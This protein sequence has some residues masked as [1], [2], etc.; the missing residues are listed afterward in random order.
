MS[1]KSL[2]EKLLEPEIAVSIAYIF[3][4][5]TAFV[6]YLIPVTEKYLLRSFTTPPTAAAYVLSLLG[7]SVYVVSAR[8]GKK[9]EIKNGLLILFLVALTT[10]AVVNLTLKVHS[11][12]AI[13]SGA[14][15]AL[16]LFYLGRERDFK[17]LTKLVFIFAVLSALSIL[18]R[19]IPILSASARE[20][21]AISTS[22][23]LFH[24]FGVFTGALL[25]GFFDK[26]TAAISV[27]MLAIIGVLSGF[28][29]DA[30]AIILSASI[31]G[32]LLKK[33]SIKTGV[34]SLVAIAFILTG[35]STFIALVA[36]DV[37]NIPPYLYPFYRFGF[38]F[39]VFSKVVELALPF[40]WLHGEAILDTTQMIVSTAVLGYEKPHIITS[41]LLGPLT[42]DF[43]VMGT[44]FTAVL[45]GFYMG[46]MRKTS[47]GSV[48][49]TCLYAMALTHGLVLIEVGLQLSSIMFLL[50]MM[51]L[52]A[53]TRLPSMNEIDSKNL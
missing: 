14:G 51:Y 49:G 44:I 20:A 38:T 41:T 40:G 6:S 13:L 48:L 42:L 12:L 30:I 35:V 46:V 43:G 2:Q 53:I 25:V 3:F 29:S 15:F 7:I 37:W 47:Q 22:R 32:L 39:S 23:A 26:K 9:H 17:K 34:L 16:L 5:A 28:K 19:G 50:A 36:H 45:I 10:S 24:G 33:I 52:S 18:V 4:I 31:A 8:L 21:T 27:I 11:I 1:T